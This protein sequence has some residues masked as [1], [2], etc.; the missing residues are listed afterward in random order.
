MPQ[1]LI[2]RCRRKHRLS[3]LERKG[4]ITNNSSRTESSLHTRPLQAL[5]HLAFLK[6]PGGDSSIV[7]CNE[8]D[9]PGRP[10]DI[11]PVLHSS[12][13]LMAAKN[14]VWSGSALPQ[15]PQPSIVMAAALGGKLILTTLSFRRVAEAQAF[16][17]GRLGPALSPHTPEAHRK[18]GVEESRPHSPSRAHG[19]VL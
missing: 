16:R 14:P 9:G 17:S 18:H 10:L 5:P 6:V 15:A 13:Q 4:L 1:R 8:G 3:E 12:A 11:C 19:L 2:T 7:S